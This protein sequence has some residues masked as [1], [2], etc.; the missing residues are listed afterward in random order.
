MWG[1]CKRSNNIG[2]KRIIVNTRKNIQVGSVIG[3]FKQ[4]SNKCISCRYYLKLHFLCKRTKKTGDNKEEL[5]KRVLCSDLF[6]KHHASS[7][8]SKRKFILFYFTGCVVYFNINHIEAYSANILVL[9]FSIPFN[10]SFS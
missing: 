7:N 2:A 8:Q 10:S 1:I 9:F 6:R 5:S 3:S 4:K